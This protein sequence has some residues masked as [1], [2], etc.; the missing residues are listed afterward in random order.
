MQLWYGNSAKAPVILIAE[1]STFILYTALNFSAV[2]D[3]AGSG[4]KME[5]RVYGAALNGE[6][7]S[8][9]LQIYK[10]KHLSRKS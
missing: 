3:F 9:I 6:F 7:E 4:C 5:G 1:A 2:G 8:C 10:S